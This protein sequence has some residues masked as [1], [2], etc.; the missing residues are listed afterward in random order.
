MFSPSG[1]NKHKK[2]TFYEIR[3]ENIF[4]IPPCSFLAVMMGRKAIYFDVFK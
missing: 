3:F 1:T 2:Q 4:S